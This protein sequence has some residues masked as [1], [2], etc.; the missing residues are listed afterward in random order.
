VKQLITTSVSGLVLG[1]PLQAVA[2]NANTNSLAAAKMDE[3]YT[4]A[5]IYENAA[6]NF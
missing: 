6:D 2:Y 5:S 4:T 3:F 1:E